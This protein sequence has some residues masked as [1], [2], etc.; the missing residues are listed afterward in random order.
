MSNKV[1]KT[2]FLLSEE[3]DLYYKGYYKDTKGNK[4]DNPTKGVNDAKDGKPVNG[5]WY[6]RFPEPFLQ[7]TN[8]RSIEVH[9]ITVATKKSDG[10]DLLNRESMTGDIIMH[11]DFIKR[12][13]Y[14]K[15]TVM[16]CNQMRTKFKKYAYTSPDQIFKVWFTSFV[17]KNYRF[18]YDNTKFVIEMMLIY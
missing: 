5:E 17:D 12:D 10:S 15:H 16:L 13:A 4:I 8:P 7:S 14:L 3:D 6:F 11:A 1:T 18:A 2:Y 9:Y